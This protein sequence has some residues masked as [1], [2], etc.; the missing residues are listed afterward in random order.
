[1]STLIELASQIV[2]AQT[3]TA[4]MSTE[5]IISS[6]TRIHGTMIQLESMKTGWPVIQ[7]ESGRILDVVVQP[8]SG[9]PSHGA[10]DKVVPDI[11]VNEA[12]RDKEV[13]C[14]LCSKSFQMLGVHLKRIHGIRAAEYRA[15]FG[16]PKNR[17]L[18]SN[19]LLAEL[20]GQVSHFGDR[21]KAPKSKAAVESP[22][23]SKRRGRPRK[24]LE[25]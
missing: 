3:A 1:M 7:P 17:P 14:L 16:I 12:F 22:E 6:L 11:P 15:K 10:G 20:K 23:E 9:R 5:E 4:A 13:I 25:L 18:L 8:E 24:V 21:S 19:T 2:T